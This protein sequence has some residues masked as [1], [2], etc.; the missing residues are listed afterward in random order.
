MSITVGDR[1]PDFSV[2]DDSGAVFTQKELLGQR[3]IV[4]FYPKD[5]TSGCTKEACG[6]NELLPKLAT[7]GVRIVGV[8]R[9]SI[10]DHVKFK[11]KHGLQFPLL[12]DTEGLLCTA[13]GVWV[14]KSLYGRNY[15]G[16]ER[17]TFLIDAQ[18]IVE[19]IW[20]TVKVAGHAEEVV[21]HTLLTK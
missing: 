18:G 7:R 11:N 6:F 1:I 14:E 20:R 10:Q 2:T 13:F 8:S 3:S 15:Q 5:D 17:S 9:D 19:K 16:I 4:Y 21:S 12:A